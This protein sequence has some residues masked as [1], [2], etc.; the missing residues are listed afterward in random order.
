[1]NV[2]NVPLILGTGVFSTASV[3]AVICDI[4]LSQPLS[5]H[6]SS[7]SVTSFGFGNCWPSSLFTS[8]DSPGRFIRN[9]SGS[10]GQPTCGLSVVFAS[11]LGSW[12]ARR[13]SFVPGSLVSPLGSLCPPRVLSAR[14]SS[15]F[16]APPLGRPGE[17]PCLVSLTIAIIRVGK[18]FV[19]TPIC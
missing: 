19:K 2:A 8:E 4:C 17:A 6:P 14:V 11:G 1:M 7:G 18:P 10:F 16:P 12:V 13:L 15:R 3:R 9:R 5:F